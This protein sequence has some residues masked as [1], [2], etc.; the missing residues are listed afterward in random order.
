MWFMALPHPSAHSVF[1]ITT[2]LSK[3]SLK[4]H[5]SKKI[6]SQTE[7][8]EMSRGEGEI[9]TSDRCLQIRENTLK[10]KYKKSNKFSIQ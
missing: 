7:V 5:Q 10:K 2:Y 1:S 8:A 3:V 9:C 4:I 6:C